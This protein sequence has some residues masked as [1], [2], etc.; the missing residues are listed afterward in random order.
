MTKHVRALNT[1]LCAVVCVCVCGVAAAHHPIQAKFD[2]AANVALEG[3]VT[4][5]DWRNPHAH[6]FMNV[7]SEAGV[8]NWAVE[9]ESPIELRHAGWDR[10]TLT[11]GDA[12]QV[13]GL[14]ARDGSRQLWA[15]Y[16]ARADGKRLPLA[17]THVAAR[18][19][20]ARP[21]PRWP[22]GRVAL[23]AAP[24]GGVGGYWAHPSETA[25]VEDGVDVAMD[26]FGQLAN[27]ADARRVA[28]LQPWA[29]A[30]YRYRQARHQQDDPTYLNC[31]P[32]GGPR[33]YQSDLGLRLVEDRAR[34]RIFVLL[35]SGNSNYRIIYLDGR[36]AVGQVGGDDDNPL[37][38]GRAVGSWDGDTLVVETTGFNEDFWMTYGG[39]PHTNFLSLTERFTR[40][41]YDTLHYEVTIDDRG[42]YTRPWTA[43]WDMQWVGGAELPMYLCQENRP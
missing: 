17:A 39:L 1:G 20:S 40:T 16:V 19:L 21:P 4:K 14:A 27:L 5:V 7:R 37:Y 43:S 15:E 3:V 23:G 28:P 24:N 38:Y 34:E 11:P 42:A 8:D 25:L 13:R 26:K 32:P 33:Q 36:D 9:L 2:A 31:K 22:D 30:L 6:V 10:T 12:I 18:P 35:G 41:D 29:L